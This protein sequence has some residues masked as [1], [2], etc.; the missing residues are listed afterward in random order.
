MKTMELGG[1]RC[2]VRRAAGCGK[3]FKR[4]SFVFCF[5]NFG[6]IEISSSVHFGEDKEMNILEK[7]DTM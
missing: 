2:T 5:L 1:R 7:I 3:P 4:L 6:P